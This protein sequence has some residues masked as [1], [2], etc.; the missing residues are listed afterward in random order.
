MSWYKPAHSTTDIHHE[1]RI[2]MN[3]KI[4]HTV[5]FHREFNIKMGTVKQQAR[6][7]YTF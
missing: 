7:E 6:D 4:Y 5:G 1:Q 3:S 2:S